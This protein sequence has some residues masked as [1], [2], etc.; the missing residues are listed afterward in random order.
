[1]H[2]LTIEIK[3]IAEKTVTEFE[4]KNMGD[5]YQLYEENEEVIYYIHSKLKAEIVS[6]VKS[7]QELAQ[8]KMYNNKLHVYNFLK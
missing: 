7:V 5:F 6:D 3:D 2:Q 4:L 8:K 1:M